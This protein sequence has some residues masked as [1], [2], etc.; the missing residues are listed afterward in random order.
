MNESITPITTPYIVG[1]EMFSDG[2]VLN[3]FPADIIQ[4]DCEKLIGAVNGV[5]D[6]NRFYI[7]KCLRFE[8]ASKIIPSTNV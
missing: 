8:A 5:I 1:N 6:D 7:G 3:N 4:N 2:G